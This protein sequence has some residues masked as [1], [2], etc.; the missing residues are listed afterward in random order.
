MIRAR[1]HAHTAGPYINVKLQFGDYVYVPKIYHELTT[2][3]ILVME[4][5]DGVKIS[6]EEKIREMGYEYICIMW[7]RCFVTGLQQQY[8]K[9][10]SGGAK[11]VSL[12]VCMQARVSVPIPSSRLLT[13]HRQALVSSAHACK[14]VLQEMRKGKLRTTNLEPQGRTVSG[15]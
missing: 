14:I 6:E 11:P 15:H 10:C 1:T 5:I 8:A 9:V 13:T 3:R 12:V 4:W 7:S 2:P